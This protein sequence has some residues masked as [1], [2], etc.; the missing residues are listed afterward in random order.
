MKYRI[1]F[2]WIATILTAFSCNAFSASAQYNSQLDLNNPQYS[3][4]INGSTGN[5]AADIVRVDLGN[6]WNG[7]MDI[8]L[9]TGNYTTLGTTLGFALTTDPND[10]M[11][12][13]PSAFLALSDPNAD[14]TQFFNDNVIGWEMY[15]WGSNYVAPNTTNNLTDQF[16]PMLFDPNVNYYAFIAGGSLL[17]T[18]VS[19]Q[20]D[21]SDGSEVSAVP[22]PA[23]LWLFGSGLLGIISLNKRRKTIPA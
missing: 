2:K 17:P 16:N 7:E 23:A 14:V 18:T 4:N 13:D 22:V 9:T 21:V 19:L 5:I 12:N 1:G 20:L 8:Q 11:Y 10:A 6:S 15:S 3:V